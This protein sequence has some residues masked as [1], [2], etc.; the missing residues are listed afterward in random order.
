MASISKFQPDRCLYI[1][2]FDGFGASAALWGAS[3]S[4]FTVSG[5]F[6]A[7][8]DFAVLVIYDADDFFEHP[9]NRY[10]PDFDLTGLVLEFDVTYTGLQPLDSDKYPT[11]D[12]PYLDVITEAGASVQVPLFAHATQAGGTYAQASATV[13]VSAAPAVAYDRVTIWYE[14]N[15]ADFI[16]SGGETAATVAANLAAQISAWT[17]LEATATGPTILIRARK[18]G[19]DGNL[20]T[21]YTQS[22]TSTLT[23]SPAV[24][25]LAGGSSDAVWHIKLDFSALGIPNIRQAWMTFAPP[26]TSGPFTALEWQAV[27]TGWGITA[28]PNNLGTF[29]VAAP[30]S[31]RVEETDSWCKLSGSGWSSTSAGGFYSK[32]FAALT[33]HPGDSATVSYWCQS[34]HDLY[35]GTA[36]WT[37][38]GQVSVSIDGG[39]PV[40]VDTYLNASEPVVTRRLVA[41]GISPGQHTVTITLLGTSTG[42]GTNFYFDFLEAAVVG[43]PPAWATPDAGRSAALDYDTDSTYKLSPQRLMA[44]FDQLGLAGPMNLYGGVFWALQ[45]KA[46]GGVLPQVTLDFGQRTY[47]SGTGVGDGDQVFIEVGTSLYGKTIFPAD[48]ADSIASHFAYFLNEASVG[49]WASASGS[50]LTVGCRAAGSAFSFAFAAYVNHPTSPLNYTG[51]LTGGVQPNWMYDP[52]QTPALARGFRDWLADLCGEAKSRGYEL[53][54]S[55]SMEFV[56]PPDDPANGQVWAQRFPDGTPVTTATGFSTLVSTQCS[57]TTEVRLAHQAIFAAVAAIQAAAGLT[58]AVQFGEFSWW[59]FAN[60]YGMAFYDAE[61]A[62]AAI[63]SIGRPLHV[64]STPNDDPSAWPLDS[65]FLAGRLAGYVIELAAYLRSLYP[66]I[67]IEWLL[68][69]D[70]NYPE[71]VGL[72]SLGGRLIHYVNIPSWLIAPASSPFTLVKMEALDFGSADRNMTLALAAMQFPFGQGWPASKLRYLCPVF[73]GGCPYRRERWLAF[74][75]GYQV[76]LDWAKDHLELF[77]WD[78]NGKDLDMAQLL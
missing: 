77:G 23:L 41:A 76:V 18:A 56:Y 1:R 9:V 55:F 59:Y 3:P 19:V 48:T 21:L 64:F 12:W 6:R 8:D 24:V 31:V 7:A 73:N 17:D 49:V 37:S 71:P 34:V 61:T 42:G 30:G 63:V 20:I 72:Y 36:L 35:L 32:G 46:S 43:D 14:N 27:F 62:A 11:I 26:L 74:S 39:S 22:K 67:Q 78:V 57:F 13:T 15:A 29:R 66:T 45:R 54:V 69:Y 50:V 40:T 47:S 51:G 2:G 16:A 44:T 68:P 65:A 70:V 52:S 10:L 60:S 58:P 33:A 53:V 75:V 5:I 4:G 28:D 38:Y 25:P